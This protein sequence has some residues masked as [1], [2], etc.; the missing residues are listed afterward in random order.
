MVAVAAV[1][2]AP[3]TSPTSCSDKFAIPLFSDSTASFGKFTE[4]WV[5][6]FCS[7]VPTPVIASCT[8]WILSL[9]PTKWAALAISRHPTSATTPASSS[10][11]RITRNTEKNLRL[12]LAIFTRKRSGFCSAAATKNANTNGI[13]HMAVHR[14]AKMAMPAQTS[15][16]AKLIKKPRRCSSR[17]AGEPF[18]G[19]VAMATPPFSVNILSFFLVYPFLAAGATSFPPL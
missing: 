18:N 4:I 12:P 1:L 3:V 16:Y 19:G 17:S 13:S 8:I 7:E 14:I 15:Q 6:K 10:T 11:I 9:F 2:S 5:T